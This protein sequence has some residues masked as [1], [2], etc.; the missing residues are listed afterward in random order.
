MSILDTVYL[1][2]VLDSLYGFFA[3]R[4]LDT[5]ML[6]IPY[7]YMEKARVYDKKDVEAI[8]FLSAIYDYQ[9]RVGTLRNHFIKMINTLVDHGLRL[10]DLSME[11]VYRGVFDRL[12]KDIGFFHRFD[13]CGEAV[14]W[15][16]RA[17]YNIDLEY[18]ASRSSEPDRALVKALWSELKRYWSMIPCSARVRVK[19]VIPRPDTRSPLKRINLFLRW[20]VRDEYPDLVYGGV[21]I[22][23][24]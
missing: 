2:Q 21:L 6:S 23:L 20:M 17:V 22:S 1:R 13:P 16:L 24:D 8:A 4:Y 11:S 14:P 12:L 9:M 7:Y 3:R 10:N 5:S 19:R 15:I 18:V